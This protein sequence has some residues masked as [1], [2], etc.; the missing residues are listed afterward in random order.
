VADD[1]EEEFRA[2]A[3]VALLRRAAR[4][5]QRAAD[6]TVTGANGIRIVAGEGRIA[7]RIAEA[8]DQAADDLEVGL[9]VAGACLAHRRSAKAKGLAVASHRAAATP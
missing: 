2:G 5:R 3:E 6:W 8:L 1:L 4:Q 7:E 9:I